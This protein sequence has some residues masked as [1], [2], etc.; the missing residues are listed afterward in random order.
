MRIYT[1]TGD[2]GETG[3]LGPVRVPKDHIRIAAYGD[4]DELNAQI[5]LLRLAVGDPYVL[6]LLDGIQNLLF[7]AGAELARPP[8]GAGAVARL[9][10]EDVAALEGAIDRL[11]EGL[12]ALANFVLPG[13]SEAAAR[14]HVARC[15]CRRAERAVVHL[16]RAEPAETS[17]VR[18]LNRLSDLLFVLARWANHEAGLPDVLWVKG[19]PGPADSH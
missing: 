7:E 6:S 13:G 9:R 5:G 18:Y 19:S 1:R 12:P 4:V 2:G 16:L 8:G 11:E 14:A 10:D 15:V 3:L 17:V